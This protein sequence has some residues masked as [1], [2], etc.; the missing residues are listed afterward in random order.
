MLGSPTTTTVY[1]RDN[2]PGVGFE[3]SLYTNA[4]GQA[5]D[6]AVTVL[7][8]NDGALGP[9]TVDYATGDGTATAGQ[10]YQAVSGTLTFP[11]NETVGS[12]NIPILQ[13]RAAGSPKTFQVTLS[14]PHRRCHAGD[15]YHHRKDCGRLRHGG[16]SV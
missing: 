1:I 5:G 3:L 8:G 9:F 13:P 10:D 7:R 11:E 16:A 4:W 6:F 2:D 15:G 14:N 12:L